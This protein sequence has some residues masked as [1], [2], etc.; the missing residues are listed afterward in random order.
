MDSTACRVSGA[1]S[2][3]LNP[4]IPPNVLQQTITLGAQATDA[5]L[6]A[7]RLKGDDVSWTDGGVKQSRHYSGLPPR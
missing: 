3:Q 2:I 7:L 5:D 1:R 6:R 4:V